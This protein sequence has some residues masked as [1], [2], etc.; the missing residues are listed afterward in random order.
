MR[1]DLSPGFGSVLPHTDFRRPAPRPLSGSSGDSACAVPATHCPAPERAELFIA[2]FFNYAWPGCGISIPN[3]IAQALLIQREPMVSCRDA[4]VKSYLESPRSANSAISMTSRQPVR[5]HG[6]RIGGSAHTG[7]GHGCV[8]GVPGGPGTAGG[9]AGVQPL[10]IGHRDTRTAINSP[11]GDGNSEPLR[12]RWSTGCRRHAPGTEPSFPPADPVV[13]QGMASVVETSTARV[14]VR[15]P[16]RWAG[17][18]CGITHGI[19][20]RCHR[21]PG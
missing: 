4:M 17:A 6:L 9:G 3:A 8:V 10:D 20:V 15:V 21:R 11:R 18:R 13:G 12:I 7:G 14:T 1:I 2:G 16:G 5:R 19:R